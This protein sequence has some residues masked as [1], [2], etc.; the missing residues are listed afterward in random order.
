MTVGKLSKRKWVELGKLVVYNFL[1][2]Y[3]GH[4]LWPSESAASHLMDERVF[5]LLGRKNGKKHT[6]QKKKTDGHALEAFLENERTVSELQKGHF[7]T[8]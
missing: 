1:S 4:P 3:Q 7:S 5:H 2:V 8:Q 6:K